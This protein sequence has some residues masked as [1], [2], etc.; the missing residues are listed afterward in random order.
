M[1]DS[2]QTIATDKSRLSGMEIEQVDPFKDNDWDDKVTI[3]DDHSIFHRSAWARVLTET[4]GHRPFYLRISVD[5]VEA[6][7]VPL[8]EVRSCLTGCRGVSLPFSDFTGPLWT[9]ARQASPVY[10]ALS[11]FADERS[12]KHLEIRGGAVP[13]TGAQPFLIYN[14][15]E[16]DLRQDI[17]AIERRLDPSVRKAIRKAERSGMEV[18]V[19]QSL[20]AMEIYYDLHCR[21]RKRH[22]LPPQP[23]AFF[24]AIARNLMENNLGDIVL[25][26]LG[27]LP[28][29][30]A[31][32]LHSGGHVIY[33]YGASDSAHWSLR[34]NQVVMWKAIRHF[35][36][37][38]C[39]DL[40]FGRTSQKDEG[41][42]RF[43]R[44]W[45]CES[46]ALSYFRRGRGTN[47]WNNGN[48]RVSENHSLIFGHLP[49]AL[50]RIAGQLIYPHLD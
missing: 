11:N 16:L 13:P 4:Y 7:L 40:H 21:T 18:T 8:M 10:Q 9:D 26:K 19:E 3:R 42:S 46:E 28:V 25:A 34:P 24:K 29:A 2:F 43:K 49:I 35:A 17:E 36:G 14:S 47:K 20:D 37:I 50:N 15:H 31:V 5:C 44:S 27:E 32:F 33:K 45:G 12:W 6:A 41:L 39:R 22:G 30:G 38:G 1:A 23:F 48:Q